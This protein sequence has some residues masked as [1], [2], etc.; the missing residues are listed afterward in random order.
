MDLSNL[1]LITNSYQD[2]HLI[3]LKH[4]RNA[5]AFAPPDSGGPYVVSQQ[6][7][8]PSDLRAEPDEFLLGK[9][10]TWISLG[11]FY[12]LP[13]DVRQAEFVFAT[14]A[15]VVELMAALPSEPRM[16]AREPEEPPAAAEDDEL[17]E[18][19]SEARQER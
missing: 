6:G 8:D 16:F 17:T 4:W 14:A 9:S 13:K 18:A 2:V 19:L 5:P 7:Y 3:S 15:E 10:G 1:R 11:L 12:R